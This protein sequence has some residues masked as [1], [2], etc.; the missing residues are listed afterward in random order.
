VISDFEYGL[1]WAA[2]L[3]M[4]PRSMLAYPIFSSVAGMTA[5]CN[6]QDLTFFQVG[7]LR[8][9]GFSGT[10]EAGGRLVRDRLKRTLNPGWLEVCVLGA[11]VLATVLVVAI[12][13]G[14]AWEIVTKET[15]ASNPMQVMVKRMCF[16]IPAA[17]VEGQDK[18]EVTICKDLLSDRTKLCLKSEKSVSRQSAQANLPK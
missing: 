3:E 4:I 7:L 17:S 1:P 2:N 11:G 5:V 9:T 8:E 18:T 14:S 10:G 13:T 6:P 12:A 16:M 15:V